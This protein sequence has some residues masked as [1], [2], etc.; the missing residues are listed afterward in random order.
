[1]KGSVFDRESSGT[2]EPYRVI[3]L[4]VEG[5]KTEPGYFEGLN[6][7]LSWGR[8]P[9]PRCVIKVLKKEDHGSDPGSVISLLDEYLDLRRGQY[10]QLFPPI[11]L[12]K[13]TDDTIERYFQ[14]LLSVEECLEFE[15]FAKSCGVPA[16]GLK[17]LCD[18]TTERDVFGV[19]IDHDSRLDLQEH[20][21][22][23]RRRGYSVFLTTPCFELWLLMHFVD[24]LQ[25]YDAQDLFENRGVS[26]NHTYVSRELSEIARTNKRVN[27][28]N[29]A[30]KLLDAIERSRQMG[31]D[32]YCLLKQ[33]GSNL[34]LLFDIIAGKR[35]SVW[36][37]VSEQVAATREE[38]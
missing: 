29:Y 8:L 1:L 25:E 28:D 7:E 31:D 21:E 18:P 5:K 15:G 30:D 10:D 32:I 3:F 24:V 12:E 36:E 17:R 35:E 33:P 16:E 20:L 38:P 4:S 34:H 19:V 11:F 26:K 27:F 6:R 2:L 13:Y 14:G 22:R 23:C 37:G 9:F